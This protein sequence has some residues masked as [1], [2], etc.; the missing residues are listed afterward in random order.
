[1]HR[2][3]KFVAPAA[4]LASL[5]ACTASS[6]AH[7]AQ[8]A[9]G[10]S[11]T[12]AEKTSE[13]SFVSD[14]TTAYG[15]LDIPAHRSGQRLAAALLLPGSGPTDRNG[16]EAG[17]ETADTLKLISAILTRD[18]I[19]TF[20]FDKY[21]TGR[22]GAGKYA[23]DPGSATIQGDLDQA[24]AAYKFLGEQSAA[25]PAKLLVLGHSEG[26]MIALQIATSAAGKPAGLAL[27][28][29]QDARILDLLRIQFDEAVNA[30]VANG[31]LSQAQGTASTTAIA[32]AITQ[33]RANQPVSTDGMAPQ[34]VQL[35]SPFLVSNQ[36]PTYLRTW[37]AVRPAVL[38]TKV[39]RGT[40]VLVTDGT[41]D[42]NV[43]ITTIHPL[44]QALS[45]AGTTGPGLQ[46]IQGTD[47]FMHLAS[48]P[49]TSAVL[50][51]DIVTAI[52]QWA[53][54]FASTR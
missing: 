17:G 13:V 37:D 41:L 49:D 52:T 28:E 44:V 53:R 15:T 6:G 36:Q 23:S 40:Q 48:Q 2:F 21:F 18:G 33:F 11:R 25:D 26:G 5:V 19:M 45:A 3:L 22:T 39:Q 51:P 31:T 14:G 10:K 9:P 54:P 30:L 34:I 7:V 46:T 20:R 29:P 24:D 35:V 47:H 16:N 50:A 8:T 1:V 4:A 42:T 32:G 27:L 43:P 38:A 12:V